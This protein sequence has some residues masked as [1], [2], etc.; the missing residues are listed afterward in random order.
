MAMKQKS[1]ELFFLFGNEVM[2]NY[3][4]VPFLETCQKGNAQPGTILF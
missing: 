2:P 3:Y 1:G 4:K